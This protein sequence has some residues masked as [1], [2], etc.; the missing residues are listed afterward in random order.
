MLQFCKIS[1]SLGFEQMKFTFLGEKKI[2]NFVK[3]N[4]LS[5]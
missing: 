4:F 5:L 1:F 3:S 2:E